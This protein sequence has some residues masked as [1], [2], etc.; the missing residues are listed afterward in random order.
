M[1]KY[2]GRRLKGAYK[3]IR[4]LSTQEWFE[5]NIVFTSEEVSPILGNFKVKYSPHYKKLFQLV[6]RVATR[7]LFAKW[8][9]QAGKS[10]FGV[11][12]AACRLDQSP[13]TIIYAQ[14]VNKDIPKILTL[15][16]NPV[17]RSMKKLW[18]K[19]EDYSNDESFRTKDAIKRVAGGS[20]VITGASVKERKSLTSPMI[21]MDEIAEFLEGA[22]KEFSERTKSFSRFNP[23]ILGLSTI[24]HPEDEVCVNHNLCEVKLEWRFVCP[25]DNCKKDFYPSDETLKI[26]SKKQYAREKEIKE[27]D[28]RLS[29]FLQYAIDMVY[30]ECPHCGYK[31]NEEKRTDMILNDEMDWFIIH[32]DGS[33]EVLIVENLARESSFGLDMNSLGSYFAP[34]SVIVEEFIG[35]LGNDILLDKFYRGWL[36]KF[37]EVMSKNTNAEDVLLLANNY[38]EFEI[39]DDT[40]G[41]YMGI[42]SQKGY[43]WVTI[44]AIEY[45][46]IENLV[47]AGRV[48]DEDTIKELFERDYFY[49][50]GKKYRAGVRRAYHDWQGYRE[51]VTEEHVNRDTGEVMEELVMDMPQRVKVF[52]YNM[53]KR[54]GEDEGKEK[55]YLVEGVR[56]VTSG[57]AYRTKTLNLEVKGYSEVRKLKSLAISK[58]VTITSFLSA[59]G[60]AIVLRKGGE[61]AEELYEPDKRLFF[62]NKTAIESLKNRKKSVSKDL[63]RQLTSQIWGVHK[64]PS[65]VLDK[66]MSFKSKKGSDDHYLDNM[67]YIQVSID[68]DNLSTIRKPDR[69]EDV[70][71]TMKGIRGILRS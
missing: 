58:T 40:I 11:G 44:V 17:L 60:R 13:A 41:L 5:K 50:D 56:T 7:K 31:I 68:M 42:D 25:E 28:V 14:P 9:S 4:K 12:V 37:Y 62:I 57:M 8:A 52:G 67:S 70:K 53:A 35:A 36:N 51:K 39:P 54:H 45:N 6:D 43:Y 26:I 19:F 21:V 49:K 2:V 55:Y 61:K 29:D 24:V 66:E 71:E 65:G 27:E 64:S 23:L 22:V 34:L 20:L 33:T 38:E 3:R 1:L 47:W 30:I 59:M 18:Q 10:L 69:E 15:K 48:E 46:I 63:D 32:E 16:I